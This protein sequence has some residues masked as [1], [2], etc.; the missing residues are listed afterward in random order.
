MA[1]AYYARPK[2]IYGTPQE[3]RDIEA[4]TK[5]GFNVLDFKTEAIQ[6]KASESDNPMEEVFAPL[7]LECK[8]LFFRAFPDGSIAAGVAKEIET[9]QSAGIPVAEL[10]RMIDFRSIGVEDTRQRLRELGQR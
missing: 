2:N 5:F 6:R 4:I 10:P 9:A 7:V 3:A 8:A 1:G